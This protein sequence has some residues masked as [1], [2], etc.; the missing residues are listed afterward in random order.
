MFNPDRRV[1][2]EFEITTA[3]RRVAEYLPFSPAWIAAMARVEELEG[4][5]PTASRIHLDTR[6]QAFRRA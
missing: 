3:R 6:T 1:L 4:K 5:L 2:L